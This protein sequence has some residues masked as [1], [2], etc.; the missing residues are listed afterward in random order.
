MI[1]VILGKH[2]GKKDLLCWEVTPEVPYQFVD[3]KSG[4]YAIVENRNDY[5]MVKVVCVAEI[6]EKYLHL[7]TGGK[8]LKKVIRF[9]E[10][11]KVRED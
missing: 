10:R 6:E 11:N 4:N 2:A 8:E 5:A 7:L 9:V 1:K 3:A